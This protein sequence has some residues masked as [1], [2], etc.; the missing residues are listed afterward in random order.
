LEEEHIGKYDPLKDW[1]LNQPG[2]RLTLSFEDIED[3]DRIGAELP[4]SAREYRPWWGNEAKPGSRQ[5]RAWLDTG[6]KVD[7]VDLSK[8]VVTFMRNIRLS[9]A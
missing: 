4:K 8:E 2:D 9:A 5:C 6:W 7:A 3:E 1:L